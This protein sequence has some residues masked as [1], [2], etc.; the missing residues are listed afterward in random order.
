MKKWTKRQIFF[1]F[2]Q[3]FSP[4]K[5]HYFSLIH[6]KIPKGVQNFRGEFIFKGGGMD[7]GANKHPNKI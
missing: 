5:T 6:W 1:L 3:N 2:L 7:F 4:P